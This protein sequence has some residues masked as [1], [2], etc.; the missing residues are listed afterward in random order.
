MNIKWVSDFEESSDFIGDQS[1]QCTKCEKWFYYPESCAKKI[2]YQSLQGETL[3]I[4]WVLE[5]LVWAQIWSLTTGFIQVGNLSPAVSTR[6]FS[7]PH[8]K[9]IHPRE[10]L[11]NAFSVNRMYISL[12]I[13]KTSWGKPPA[14]VGKKKKPNK[15]LTFLPIR[16]AMLVKNCVYVLSMAKTLVG[17]PYLGLYPKKQKLVWAKTL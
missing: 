17:E 3:H 4:C 13:R 1:L 11:L 15:T 14:S 12:D 7:S 10:Q 6:A 9:R 16:E 2:I 8:C 5:N